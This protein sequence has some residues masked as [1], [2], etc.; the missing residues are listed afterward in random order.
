MTWVILLALVGLTLISLEIIIP[1]GILG[2]LGGICTIAACAVS[3]GVFG[4]LGGLIAT[5]IIL[6]GT[7]V[8]IWLEFKFLSKTSLGRRAFLTKSV[9]G[10]SSAYG[11]DAKQ[12]IG[13][14]ATAMTTLAP[15]GYIEIEGKRYDAYCQG[16][17]TEAGTD[18]KVVGADNF[19]LIV[20]ATTDS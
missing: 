5:G 2:A 4:S 15:S 10:V 18:L 14:T 6:I 8:I 20:E 12:L 3:F 7:G 16:G 13:K 17:L 1:G 9:S 19:R 11:E